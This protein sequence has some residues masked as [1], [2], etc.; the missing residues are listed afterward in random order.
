MNQKTYEKIEKYMLSCMNDG[1]HDNQHIYRVLYSALDIADGFTVDRDV[2][3]AASLLHDIGRDAQFKNPECDHAIV[4][5]EMACKF[6]LEIGWDK[7]KAFQVKTC[8]ETHRFRNGNPPT[9]IEAKILYDADKL[10]ATGTMGIA[11]TLAYKGIVSEPLY[12][13]DENGNVLDDLTDNKPSFFQEYNW[14]LKNVYDKFFTDRAR[15]IAE[16]RRK[17]SVDL[18]ESMFREVYASHKTGVHLLKKTIEESR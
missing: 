7:N 4:G 14:K 15:M 5:A 8:I 1:A 13:V 2:L 10:D 6:L 16:E 12:Y 3:I 17:A 18:Y 11:R 9:S